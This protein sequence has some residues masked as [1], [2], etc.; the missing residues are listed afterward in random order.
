MTD[1]P[2]HRTDTES[3][4]ALGRVSTLVE[5][6]PL[7]SA[8]D[9]LVVVRVRHDEKLTVESLEH[10]LAAPL[11][12][13]GEVVLHDHKHFAAY[14]N[15]LMTP[16]H[17]TVW[18]DVDQSRVTAVLNDHAAPDRRLARPPRPPAA[19]RRRRLGAV[20]QVQRHAHVS[21]PVRRAS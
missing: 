7:S 8:A 4:A 16:G 17:T 12:P 18:A 9:P 10:H 21:G 11:A 2:Q 6:F 5:P 15:R 14:V 19:A 20:E 1:A 3:A 13:R